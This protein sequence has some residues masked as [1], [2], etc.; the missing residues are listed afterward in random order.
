[1]NSVLQ[2]CIEEKGGSVWK[3]GNCLC[4]K[5]ISRDIWLRNPH[6]PNFSGEK[7][8]KKRLCSFPLV[9]FFF[10]IFAVVCEEALGWHGLVDM[11][12]RGFPASCFA[13]G[14]GARG[15][16]SPPRRAPAPAQP[17]LPISVPTALPRPPI[18]PTHPA[19][20]PVTPRD[21]PRGDVPIAANARSKPQFKALPFA[22]WRAELRV[23]PGDAAGALRPRRF[24][25]DG[26]V[27]SSRG[28]SI[29]FYIFF[30][31][32]L[33][34]EVHWSTLGGKKRKKKKS[35]H[36]MSWFFY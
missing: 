2:R 21:T 23:A 36:L 24:P 12:W 25:C 3:G 8:Q 14:G 13:A 34:D 29:S 32:E 20:Q 19:A 15:C 28:V 9:W 17:P 1:M 31:T 6:V 16:E 35:L 26:D 22:R 27:T 5:E 4:W 10:I 33:F 7:R 30:S 18:A 11:I